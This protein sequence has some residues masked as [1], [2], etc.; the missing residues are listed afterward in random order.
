MNLAQYI[1]AMSINISIIFVIALGV[2]AYFSYLKKY[3]IPFNFLK[4]FAKTTNAII[5]IL[6]VVIVY[7][8]S[9]YFLRENR[10]ILSTSFLSFIALLLFLIL[11]YDRRL[12]VFLV[13]GVHVYAVFVTGIDAFI[14]E[15]FHCLN[16]TAQRLIMHSG[17]E[18]SVIFGMLMSLAVL[19]LSMFCYRFFGKRAE[20]NFAELVE[21]SNINFPQFFL[22]LLILPQFVLAFIVVF[23]LVQSLCKNVK[24]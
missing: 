6:F 15:I 5:V 3:K 17:Q 8:I 13:L 9:F 20:Q 24:F 1:V 23:Y 21:D 14:S 7:S 11:V 12:L 22:K 19:P 10:R 18:I 4:V 16:L 2:F